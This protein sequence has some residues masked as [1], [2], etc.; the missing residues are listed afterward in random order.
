MSSPPQSGRRAWLGWLSRA[1]FVGITLVLAVQLAVR[2]YTPREHFPVN[3][4]VVLIST[5][6]LLAGFYLLLL[7]FWENLSF[8]VALQLM[9]DAMLITGLVYATGATESLLTQ[10]Y[11]LLVIV[12]AVVLERRWVYGLVGLC[13]SGYWLVTEAALRHWLPRT[14]STPPTHRAVEVS[15]GLNALALLASAYMA[16]LLAGKLSAA[17]RELE[18]QGHTLESLRALNDNIVRSMSGGLVTTDLEGRI[19][20]VNQSAENILE[21]PAA[22]LAGRLVGQVLPLGSSGGVPGRQE[23]PLWVG[24]A[25][26]PGRE[27]I[28]GLTITA[29]QVEGQGTVGRVYHFQDLTELRSLE[30]E[31]QVRERMSALGRLAAGIAHEIRNPLASLAGSVKLLGRYGAI[32]QDQTKLLAIVIKESE[33]LNRIVTDFLGYARGRNYDMARFD[34]RQSLE[35]VLLLARNSPRCGENVQ[36]VAD[37]GPAPIWMTA[38][39]DR[40]KQVFWNLCDNAMKAMNGRGRLRIEARPSAVGVRLAFEDSGCGLKPGSEETIF[41]PFHSGFDDGTGLGLATAYAIVGA[42]NGQIWAERPEGGGA[43]FV[44]QLPL[45]ARDGTGMSAVTPGSDQRASLS[46]ESTA[47]HRAGI[48]S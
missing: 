24:G 12:A 46:V 10:V 37:L 42:H 32:D 41:E 18:Q 8:Q 39:A 29:L 47:G 23:F 26:G 43:R 16:S 28:L 20:L 9:L 34:L 25:A 38:D 13:V 27:K 22:E 48:R 31:V 11:V 17:D 15:V 7:R 44:L 5:W 36:L 45:D 33:R 19:Y 40:L 2:A 1:R 35:E 14:W 3:L 6:Y 30:R 4:F 21:R